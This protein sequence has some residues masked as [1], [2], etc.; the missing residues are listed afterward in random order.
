MEAFFALYKL[1]VNILVN[2]AIVVYFFTAKDNSERFT[3]VVAITGFYALDAIAGD[4]F[5]AQF[6]IAAW[7]VLMNRPMLIS[8]HLVLGLLALAA[9]VQTYSPEFIFVSAVLYIVILW[10]FLY[11]AFGKLA[12]LK[13]PGASHG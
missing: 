1:V 6:F 13:L 2:L 9:V 10:G 4:I 11:G 7:L 12:S 5:L 8:K 3:F